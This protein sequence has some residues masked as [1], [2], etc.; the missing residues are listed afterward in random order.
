MTVKPAGEAPPIYTKTGE[1]GTTGCPAG[2]DAAPGVR[3][4]LTAKP[5]TTRVLKTQV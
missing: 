1:D 2:A 5:S 3:G 4:R